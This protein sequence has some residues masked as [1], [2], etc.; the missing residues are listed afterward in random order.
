MEA[1]TLVGEEIN[2]IAANSDEY[3]F[4]NKLFDEVVRLL[5]ER[6]FPATANRLKDYLCQS[7]AEVRPKVTSCRAKID[8]QSISK[9]IATDVNL[10]D[11]S[12]IMVAVK[13]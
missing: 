9:D 10:P 13:R 11:I 2:R 1:K 8:F 12:D 5:I 4:G 3:P 7:A 6:S